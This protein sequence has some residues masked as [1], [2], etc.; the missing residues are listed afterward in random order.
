MPVQWALLDGNLNHPLIE[1]RGISPMALNR[2]V[3]P[4]KLPELR[5]RVMEYEPL[6]TKCNGTDLPACL[7]YI[8]VWIIAI[9]SVSSII[10]YIAC[11]ALE[12]PNMTTTVMHESSPSVLLYSPTAA[13][14]MIRSSGNTSS[15]T[16]YSPAE[17]IVLDF[18][19]TASHSVSRTTFSNRVILSLA[20]HGPHTSR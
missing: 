14:R 10:Q 17:E 3:G 4:C 5:F 15:P 13:R 19:R 1:H 6:A 16:R 7:Y 11:R 12:Y 20:G 9:Y 2:F 8:D 18:K